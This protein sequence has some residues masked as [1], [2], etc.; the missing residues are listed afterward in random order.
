MT[1]LKIRGIKYKSVSL[2]VGYITVGYEHKSIL[3]IFQPTAGAVFGRRTQTAVKV[4]QVQGGVR[5]T[6]IFSRVKRHLAFRRVRS[7]ALSA[8]R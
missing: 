4:S 3:S 1:K 6:E 2:D 5:G 7:D 8:G